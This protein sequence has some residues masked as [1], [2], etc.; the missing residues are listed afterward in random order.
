MYCYWSLSF[1]WLVLLI[2][3]KTFLVLWS[4]GWFN[5]L[6]CFVCGSHSCSPGFKPV[7]KQWTVRVG[8]ANEHC[9]WQWQW[10]VFFIQ[11]CL[12][13]IL[14]VL[15]CWAWAGCET[16]LG[17]KENLNESTDF[18]L[19]KIN[20]MWV[21]FMFPVYVAGN[22]DVIVSKRSLCMNI[23]THFLQVIWRQLFSIQYDVYISF[24]FTVTASAKE[25]Y[26][27]GDCH[28]NLMRGLQSFYMFHICSITA[29]V[30]S[31]A[32]WG[33]DMTNVHLLSNLC[34]SWSSNQWTRLNAVS[35]N[36]Y[37]LNSIDHW[38]E[39]SV[40]REQGNQNHTLKTKNHS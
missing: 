16:W 3:W 8:F 34:P 35:I 10:F 11:Y 15:R 4:L 32:T 22:V 40:C 37:Y 5:T 17:K 14:K 6:R 18:L 31:L 38:E 13:V 26:N 9:A 23:C 2:F 39:W 21:K 7:S 24:P 19:K 25:K 29:A 36:I 33:Q 28:F 20:K 1:R 12:H 27:D 30:P